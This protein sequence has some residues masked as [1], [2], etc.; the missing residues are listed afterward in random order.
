MTDISDDYFV[1]STFVPLNIERLSNSQEISGRRRRSFN[2]VISLNNRS[3]WTQVREK[4][5][6]FGFDK[7][8]ETIKRC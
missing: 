5:Q 2:V 3:V 6:G 4:I 1:Y 7:Y 8:Q